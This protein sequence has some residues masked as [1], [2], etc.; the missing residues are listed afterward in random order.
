MVPSIEVSG[1]W[2][3][4]CG[5]LSFDNAVAFLRAGDRLIVSQSQV[6]LDWSELSCDSVWVGVLLAWMRTAQ[7]RGCRL[8]CRGF[9]DGMM[10][11][12][13]ICGVAPLL[14]SLT[15]DEELD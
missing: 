12:A 4:L 8:S 13:K 10:R 7:A 1:D 11:L 6:K 15:A 14:Q 5:H 9:S 3:R 2:Q